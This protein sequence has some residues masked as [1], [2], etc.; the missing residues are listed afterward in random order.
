MFRF[1]ESWIIETGTEPM[2]D[3]FEGWLQGGPEGAG[4]FPHLLSWWHQ[5]HSPDV[6]L[7]S[8]A[9]M[10]EQPAFQIRKLGKLCGIFADDALD[11]LTSNRSRHWPASQAQPPTR[12]S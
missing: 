1:M 7:L 9:A 2:T 5:R 8:Y 4:H 3:F 12:I 10:I 6:M 11:R